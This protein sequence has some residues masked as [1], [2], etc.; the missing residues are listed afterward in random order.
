MAKCTAIVLAAG[1]GKRMQSKVAKQFMEIREHPVIWYS[2][3]TFQK[4][5]RIDEI[6]L[7]T[8]VDSVDYCRTEIVEKCGFSKVRAVIA[9]GKERYDSV[10]A[11]LLACEDSDYVYIHDG[12]RPFVTEEIIQRGW[13]GV[14]QS[15]ACV[16]GMP[17]KDTVK[18]ADDS[19]FVKETPER[20][21]VWTI[22][23]PQIF[24]YDLIREA[25]EQ[26]RKKDMSRVTDDAMVVES[27]TGAAVRLEQGSYHNIKI[28]TPEDLIIAEAFVQMVFPEDSS[29]YL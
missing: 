20:T 15:G 11:G 5:P 18:V 27:E 14:Q 3:R 29:D 10:Y 1:V 28:T 17:S 19:G 24:R 12:A 23:T 21:R 26:I 7:V 13:Q 6:I 16:I 9:G 4:S 25:H 8:N 2:L 22:Q